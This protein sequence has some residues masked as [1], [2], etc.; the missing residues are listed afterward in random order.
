MGGREE[1]G[2]VVWVVV[3]SQSQLV[4]ELDGKKGRSREEDMANGQNGKRGL[5]GR[6]WPIG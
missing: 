1:D 3:E 2:A 6:R 4:M 5:F